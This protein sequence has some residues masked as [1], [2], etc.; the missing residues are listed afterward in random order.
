MESNLLSDG[1]FEPLASSQLFSVSTDENDSQETLLQKTQANLNRKDDLEQKIF[2]NCLFQVFDLSRE[3]LGTI[4]VLK[5][6]EDDNV[7]LHF[8]LTL[9]GMWTRTPIDHGDVVR[10]IGR[11]TKQNHYTLVLDDQVDVDDDDNENSSARF[12]ILEPFFMISSTTIVS[13]FPC[14]RKALFSDSFRISVTDFSYALVLGNII[15]DAF[16]RILQT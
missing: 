8:R 16:E 12:L 1:E 14:V 6:F 5:S 7:P 10:V 11:F 13:S 9:R 4:V 3:P 2:D 15:H